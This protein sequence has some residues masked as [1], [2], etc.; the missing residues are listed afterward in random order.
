MQPMVGGPWPTIVI[1]VGSSQSI[2]SLLSIRDRALSYLT[3][4]NVVILVSYNRDT[5]RQ[6]DTWWIHIAARDI[7]APQPPPGAAIAYP[8]CSVLYD[9]PKGVNNRYPRVEIPLAGDPIWSIPAWLFYWPEP[10]PVYNPPLPVSMSWLYDWALGM[11]RE[12][13]TLQ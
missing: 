1:E 8:N 10:V 9:L 7:F 6:A 11:C 12:V 4:I 13:F 3:Q 2:S 5:T